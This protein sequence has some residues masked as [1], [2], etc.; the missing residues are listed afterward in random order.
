[1][2]NVLFN[3]FHYEYIISFFFIIC[4]FIII[5]T[6]EAQPNTTIIANLG[7][8][9]IEKLPQG[10]IINYVYY[11]GKNLNN[12]S[13]DIKKPFPTSKSTTLLNE[14]VFLTITTCKAPLQNLIKNP[15]IPPANQLEVW[16]S[17]ESKN[18][19][20]RFDGG[21]DGQKYILMDGYLNVTIPMSKENHD[22]VYV[23]VYAPKLSDNYLNDYYF[24]IGASTEGFI[25]QIPIES[26]ISLDDTDNNNALIRTFYTST[27]QQPL[28]HTYFVEFTRVNGISKSL[29]AYRDNGWNTNVTYTRR[30]KDGKYQ[31]SIFISNL[32]NGTKYSALVTEESA[33]GIKSF[34]PVNFQTQSQSNC[35]IIKNLE[36]CDRV[37]YS[38]PKTVSKNTEADLAIGYDNMAKAY[39]NN[40]TLTVDQYPCNDT[41]S[42]YSLIRNCN[43]CKEAYKNWVCAVTIPRCASEDSNN[44]KLRNN[45]RINVSDQ[46]MNI[47]QPYVE[48][49]PCIDLCYNLTRSC[50][51][52]FGFSCPNSNTI[53][54]YGNAGSCNSLG[55]DFSSNPN[56]AVSIRSSSQWI[57]ILIFE[58][59]IL[60]MGI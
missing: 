6:I 14:N 20:P 2:Y 57:I 25:H 1:M 45:P 34:I 32:N 16:I 42:K 27:E 55:L 31:S 9:K 21:Y 30:K 50:P 53:S 37:F 58:F 12:N 59:I 29:C 40:F 13:F 17:T 56:A 15:K 60:I 5:P 54:T 48:V 39:F 52:S 47:S 35:V 4:Y 38:V 22:G 3:Y 23:G 8:E 46:S 19:G 26:G 44:G 7:T 51:S 43:D 18:P 24:E 11:I 10:S 49:A 33:N 41:E 28:Y 36:F